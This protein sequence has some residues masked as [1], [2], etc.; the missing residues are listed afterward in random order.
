MSSPSETTIGTRAV[1]GRRVDVIRLVWPDGGTLYDLY[2]LGV[3]VGDEA[4][5]LTDEGSLE[6]IPDDDEIADLLIEGGHVDRPDPDATP[7][8]H[9]YDAAYE[10]WVAARQRLVDLLLAKIGAYVARDYPAAD[11]LVV[12]GQDDVEGFFV[13]AQRVTAGGQL[14]DGYRSSGESSSDAWDT[15]VEDLDSTLLDF[16][17]GLTGED[18]RGEHSIPVPGAVPD[19][20]G[21]TTAAMGVTA[22]ITTSAGAD[23]AVLVIL[24]T[25]FEPDASDGGP[26]LR[27]MVNDGSAFV[28]VPHLPRDEE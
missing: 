14:I 20:T 9:A 1:L 25:D 21:H 8:D 5:C 11:E 4:E 18:Y 13:R 26:G 16:L 3:E 28:G 17:A 19:L 12:E 24:D 22:T 2:L 7:L 15:C 23:G 10:I 27:V 6:A